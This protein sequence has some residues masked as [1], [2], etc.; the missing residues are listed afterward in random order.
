MTLKLERK[1]IEGAFAKE[2]VGLYAK[3]PGNH[4]RL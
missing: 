2:V 4:H 1:A 3:S